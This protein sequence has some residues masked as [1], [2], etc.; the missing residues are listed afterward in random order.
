M[1]RFGR[2]VLGLIVALVCAGALL[3]ASWYYGGTTEY[4]RFK[5]PDGR[6]EV[7]V[8][9]H[10]MLF[11]MP[12]QGSDAPG[13]IVLLNQAGRELKRTSVGMVQLISDPRWDE[14]TVGMKLLFKWKLPAK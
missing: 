12:G 13:T 9:R 6:H 1:K 7:V 11:A 3:A 8:Y 4:A 14:D 2:V 10:P 5:S